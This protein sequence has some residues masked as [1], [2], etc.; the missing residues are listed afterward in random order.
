ML[1]HGKLALMKQIKWLYKD[2]NL[3]P[4]QLA[5]DIVPCIHVYLSYELKKT[6][7][8]ATA[9]VLHNQITQ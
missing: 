5:W 2:V 4:N 7:S 8:Y 9:L 3:T 6:S 1:Q